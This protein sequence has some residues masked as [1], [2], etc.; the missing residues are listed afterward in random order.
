MQEQIGTIIHNPT[1]GFAQQPLHFERRDNGT[2]QA[3]IQIEGG[4]N[5]QTKTM[6]NV[7]IL[8]YDRGKPSVSIHA[9]TGQFLGTQ[10]DNFNSWRLHDVEI[11]HLGPVWRLHSPG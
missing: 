1:P 8:E 2:L 10:V 5:L 6:R 7:T 9:A 11:N 3:L 4:I